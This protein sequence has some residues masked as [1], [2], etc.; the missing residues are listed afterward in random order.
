MGQADARGGFILP[1]L[2]LSPRR[3]AGREDL[4]GGGSLVPAPVGVRRLLAR[5]RR[6]PSAALAGP[7]QP[8]E[9]FHPRLLLSS[10]SSIPLL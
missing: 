9:R 8:G 5:A 7:T 1:S 10:S 4:S 3:P 6:R 2:N